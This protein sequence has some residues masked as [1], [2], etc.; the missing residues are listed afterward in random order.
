MIFNDDP[1]A[2]IPAGHERSRNFE[3]IFNIR[4]IWGFTAKYS[5]LDW[6]RNPPAL[7][8]DIVTPHMKKHANKILQTVERWAL[9]PDRAAA[10]RGGSYAQSSHVHTTVFIGKSEL[11]G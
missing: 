7:W 1:L 3:G 9:E 6:A 5:I 11:D 4:K 10:Q 8:R 2:N